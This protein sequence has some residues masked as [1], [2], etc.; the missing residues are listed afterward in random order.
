MPESPGASASFLSIDYHPVYQPDDISERE[1]LR[2]KA[3]LALRDLTG[4]GHVIS[5]VSS[6]KTIYADDYTSLSLS[7]RTEALDTGLYVTGQLVAAIADMA[8][9][10]LNEMDELPAEPGS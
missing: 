7:N 8:A 1:K 5:Q 10:C 9:A 4:L 3:L 2:Q 6:T